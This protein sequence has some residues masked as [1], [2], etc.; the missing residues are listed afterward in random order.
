MHEAALAMP[1]HQAKSKNKK[2]IQS[3][4]DDYPCT[5]LPSSVIHYYS[6]LLNFTTLE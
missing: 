3:M 2:K 5:A 1:S 4:I 6:A